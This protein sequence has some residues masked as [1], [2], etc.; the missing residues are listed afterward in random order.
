MLDLGH[1]IT[2]QGGDTQVFVGREVRADKSCF[3]W[4]KPRGKTMCNIFLLARGGDG[5]KGVIGAASTA[6]G[7]GGGASSSQTV[8]RA[9]PLAMLPDTLYIQLAGAANR[10]ALTG[11]VTCATT[12]TALTGSGTAFL[13]ELTVGSKVYDTT[14]GYAGVIA[15]ITNDTTAAFAANAGVNITAATAAAKTGWSRVLLDQAS[16]GYAQGNS[17]T[18]AFARDGN[19]AKDAVGATAGVAGAAAANVTA[20]DMPFGWS[21]GSNVQAGQVGVAGGTTGAGGAVTIPSTGIMVTSGSGGAG[22]GVAG[23][24]GSSGGGL[25]GLGVFPVVNG[26]NSAGG[27]TFPPGR[28]QDGFQP[29]RN[30]LMMYG[31]TGG[32]STGGAATGAGL[33]QASGGNG[34][35]GCGGGGSGGAFTGSAAGIP[36]LGGPGLCIITC[37]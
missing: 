2:A 24:T 5:S 37:W 32:G 30:I 36:G 22:V 31:G 1:L 10:T 17:M 7:G 11:T 19:D 18:L 23:S 26:G 6:A 13:S 27:Q 15:S 29:F 33:V 20:A 4:Q 8:L 34:M 12:G 16:L 35:P 3:V 9:I 21:L 28:G 25:T 14:G